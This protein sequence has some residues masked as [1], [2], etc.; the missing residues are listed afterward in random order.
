[1]I[2]RSGGRA[3][4]G[5]LAL[6]LAAF[7]AG[8]A[9][10]STTSESA[11]EPVATETAGAPTV[12]QARKAGT[13]ARAIENDPGRAAEILAENGMTAEGLES[14]ILEIAKDPALTDAYE[15][16]KGGASSG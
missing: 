6:L 9:G 12:E 1:M 5:V 3:R 8:C 11:T 7:A 14:M 2:A 13:V 4:A 10:S 15:E 16:A